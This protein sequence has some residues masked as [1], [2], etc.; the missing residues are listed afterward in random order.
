MPL[1]RKGLRTL[2]IADQFLA[3]KKAKG[4][5]KATLNNYSLRLM[6]FGQHFA[7]LPMAADVVEGHLVT[8]RGSENRH[9]EYRVLKTLYR[10]LH[11]KGRI[12]RNPIEEVEAP[13]V[14]KKVARALTREELRQLLDF[15]HRPV[16]KA[17]LDLLVDTGLRVGEAVSIREPWHFREGV[18]V[19]KGK[20]GE[21]EVPV[22][23]ITRDAV[24]PFLPWP[25]TTAV[26]AKQAVSRAFRRAGILGK[27]ASA[28]TLRH[29]FCRLW[30][31]DETVLEGIMG[32]TSPR[33]RRV[34][35]PYD[36][37]RA[38]EQHEEWS[39]P[40]REAAALG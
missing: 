18:V 33:M 6:R 20:V 9:G 19:V 17:F 40:V 37:K 16:D 39:S 32:W 23:S 34:Y 10:W 31:G 29:T 7:V 21:R 28:Q 13:V 25:W 24:L 26:G 1:F 14:P 12:R 15:Q 22:S 36:L 38:K 5:E 35:R 8:I 11:R 4:L 2:E 30:D 27:R 3:A